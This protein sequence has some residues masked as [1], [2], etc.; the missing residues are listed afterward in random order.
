MYAKDNIDEHLEPVCRVRTLSPSV[1]KYE[2]GELR[3]RALLNGNGAELE[4]VRDR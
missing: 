1:S 2:R 4:L 3:F